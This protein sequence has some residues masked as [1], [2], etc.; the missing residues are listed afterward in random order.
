MIIDKSFEKVDSVFFNFQPRY[1]LCFDL[2]ETLIENQTTNNYWLHQLNDLLLELYQKKLILFGILTGCNFKET[3]DKLKKLDMTIYPNFL[4]CG[5]GTEL[6]YFDDSHHLLLDQ[7]WDEIIKCSSLKEN[8]NKFLD[9]LNKIDIKLVPEGRSYNEFK[10]SYYYFVGNNTYRDLKIIKKLALHHGINVIISR[11]NKNNNDPENAYD[12]DLIPIAAGKEKVV[13]YLLRKIGVDRRDTFA[14]GD[15]KNDLNLLKFVGH[16]YAV[17]NATDELK[18]YYPNKCRF[19]H[20]HGIYDELTC[21]FK[22]S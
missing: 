21:F 19:D 13:S 6:F 15:S 8:V 11:C 17:S 20:A 22:F 7:K 12:I 10:H 5:F 14:F 16:G 18:S 1:F 9:E 2:D 4:S 3:L